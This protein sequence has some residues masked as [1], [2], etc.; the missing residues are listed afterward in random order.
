MFSVPVISQWED[1]SFPTDRIN[2]INVAQNFI[3]LESVRTLLG[4]S[5]VCLC[6]CRCAAG[7][8]SVDLKQ[9]SSYGSITIPAR[10]PSHGYES[11]SSLVVVGVVLFLT[12]THTDILIVTPFVLEEGEKQC[13]PSSRPTI[14]SAPQAAPLEREETSFPEDAGTTIT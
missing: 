5:K 14:F 2:W 3:D 6:V 11:W 13:R 1:L 4:A 9:K 10:P 8:R 7:Y 12:H